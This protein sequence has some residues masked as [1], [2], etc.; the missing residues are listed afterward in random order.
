MSVSYYP[1][2][3]SEI[4][5]IIKLIGKYKKNDMTDLN[6]VF[7]RYNVN[8][9]SKEEIYD[10]F[11]ECLQNAKVL[12]FDETYGLCVAKVQ[13]MYRGNYDFG[14]KSLT[15]L[16]VSIPKLEHY[17]TNWDEFIQS[18]N[19]SFQFNNK[20]GEKESSGVYIS[21]EKLNRLYIDYQND[22][23]L[24]NLIDVY[25]GNDREKFINVIKYC[26]ENKCGLLEANFS[27]NNPIGT[28]ADNIANTNTQA[29]TISESDKPIVSVSKKVLTIFGYRIIGELFFLIAISIIRLVMP[30]IKYTEAITAAI[31]IIAVFLIWHLCIKF[32]FRYSTIEKRQVP[33]LTKAI[34]II[35]IIMLVAYAYVEYNTFSKKVEKEVDYAVSTNQEYLTEKMKIEL[36]GSEKNKR[37]FADRTEDL[38][39][40][41]KKDVLKKL[42]PYYV[43][44]DGITFVSNYG[45]LLYARRKIKKSV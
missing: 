37:D 28:R 17:K 38:K 32:S 3:K 25:Y 12:S 14:E 16:I 26:I 1:I 19:N 21:Y 42:A 29:D 5:Q 8:D 40:E 11:K 2:K 20:L 15:N 39:K 33:V 4:I 41:A 36:F 7:A 45:A 13:K 43:I 10:C 31:S 27:I 18:K 6:E 35:W 23:V 24:R 30:E 44:V 34:S 22:T 9:R